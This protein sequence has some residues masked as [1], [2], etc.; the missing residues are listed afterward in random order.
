MTGIV[1]GVCGVVLVRTFF[2]PHVVLAGVRGGL[3]ALAA[4]IALSWGAAARR[5]R[6][7]EAAPARGP[8]SS[9]PGSTRWP[10]WRRWSGAWWPCWPGPAW[11]TPAARGGSRPSAPCWPRSSFTG[12]VAPLFPARRAAVTCTAS[13][14]GHRGRPA[15]G[16]DLHG[17]RPA[18]DPA[19]LSRR[20][21]SPGPRGPPGGTGRW[22]VTVTPD[23]RG[24]V[25]QVARG[26][27]LVRALRPAVVGPGGGGAPC[28]G[29]C[30]SRPAPGMPGPLDAQPDDPAGESARRV[31]SETG[32]PR[33][34]RPF[35]AG[36][37]RRSVHWPA[38]S[39]T[40]TLM[41]RE[42]ERQTDEPVVIE[43]VLPADPAEAEAEA[44]RVMARGRHGAWPG[45][46]GGARAPSRPT[47]AACAWSGTGSTS[48]GAWP[49][50]CP[51]PTAA[52]RRPI[53]PTGEVDDD[54]VGTGRPGQPTRAARALRPV[55]GG[56]GRH[57][58]HRHRRVLEPG[59]AQRRGGRV[60][61]SWPP[62]SATPSP[63]GGAS[64]HGRRSSPSWPSAPSA[65]SSGS[66]PR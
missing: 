30:T 43:V 55:P 13:P 66:S 54:P 59:R 40:G 31:P 29:P 23:R 28:P 4:G 21:R 18:P 20:G 33:G 10:G 32:E 47:V 44:E 5:Q 14:V 34:V 57:G 46:A 15:G 52:G 17:Q 2:G 11:P 22:Q 37:S 35:R 64:T 25:E 9:A 7:R 27:G 12:L 1:A 24:V 38:T 39:H 60:R 6:R 58:G 26:A 65:A 49:G 56:L 51:G 62:P 36:D 16:A 45:P 50:P 42:R 3:V 48:G 41:V 8:P 53:G 61:R 19:P 63:T